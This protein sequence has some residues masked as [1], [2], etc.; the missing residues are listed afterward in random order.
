MVAGASVDFSGVPREAETISPS[1]S[2]AWER[3]TMSY[4]VV[5][6]ASTVTSSKRVV[7]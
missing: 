3:S 6:P 5:R 4:V 2:W 7:R 1:S